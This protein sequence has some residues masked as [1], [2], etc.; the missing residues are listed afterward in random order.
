[1]QVGPVPEEYLVYHHQLLEEFRNASAWPKHLLV[2][3]A[4]THQHA[5]DVFA[6][7]YLVFVTGEGGH[8]AGSLVLV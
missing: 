4:W 5:V 3:Y 7:L 6:G 1:M 8:G 2:Q